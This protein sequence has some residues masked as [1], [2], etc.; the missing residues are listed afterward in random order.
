MRAAVIIAYTSASASISGRV[1]RVLLAA[2]VV[3]SASLSLFA[4]NITVSA[5]TLTFANQAVGSTSAAK[6]V[7]IANK[8]VSS[9]A[10]VFAP[11]AGFTETDNCNGNIAGGGSCKMSVYFSPTLVGKIS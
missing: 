2:L 1:S 6:I 11:S 4:Q 7:T 10:V 9:Q 3:I 5:A 8:G